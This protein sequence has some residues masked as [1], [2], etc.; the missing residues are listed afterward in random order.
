MKEISEI[1]MKSG[2]AWLRFEGVKSPVPVREILVACDEYLSLV[3]AA[4]L[5]EGEGEILKA[6]FIANMGTIICTDV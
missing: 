2:V 4:Y 5:L 6:F 3:I 1:L